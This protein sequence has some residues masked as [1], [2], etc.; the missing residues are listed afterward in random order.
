[1]RI[2]LVN[3]FFFPRVG[4]SSHV[5]EQLARNFTEAGHQVLVITGRY[6]D[7]PD[8]EMRDGYLIKRLPTWVLPKSKLSLNF[9][10]NFALVP[11]NRSKI[12]MILDEFEP[13]IV[14][15]HGQFLDLSW[16]ALRYCKKAR[17]SSVLTLHTR[18]ISPNT[19][20]NLLF[21]ILD[22]FIVLPI[23]QLNSPDLVFLID[24]EF[25]EYARERYKLKEDQ[26]VSIS[27]GVDLSNFK[28][29][30]FVL[31][32]NRNQEIQILSIGHIIPIRNRIS[33]IKSLP[34]VLKKYPKL[35]LIVVGELYYPECVGLAEK[36]GVL[37]NVDFLG[38]AKSA[39]IPKLLE[40]ATLEVHDVQGY[41]IGIASL[42]AMFA[43]VP[44]IMSAD[45]DYFPHAPLIPDI[46]FIR[47]DP[48]DHKKLADTI[49]NSLQNVEL[50]EKV[51][52]AGRMYVEE[53]FDFR[54]V[55]SDHL[56]I[57]QEELDSKFD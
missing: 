42:E 56:L 40:R 57:F 5:V 31:P 2:A 54:K 46:H 48:N 45:L 51:S 4:G 38:A 9:D 52:R 37:E 11:G 47:T 18:L 55:A 10:I 39:E 19:V 8:V 53:N 22:R 15:C 41:G 17:V 24:K 27:I 29:R 12:K 43:G 20:L 6:K 44:T 50:L 23:L 1:M 3:N 49:I 32:E 28:A 14:H 30:N 25:H 26:L 35:R 13:D 7:A 34:E 33:L 21:R 16:K 36:L